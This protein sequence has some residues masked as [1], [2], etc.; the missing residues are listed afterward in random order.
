MR[1]LGQA[2][3][4]LILCEGL[5]PQ[6]SSKSHR[7]FPP[8]PGPPVDTSPLQLP[9][10]LSWFCSCILH[11]TPALPPTG[12]PT[13]K[14]HSLCKCSMHNLL[15]LLGCATGCEPWERL[16]SRVRSPASAFAFNSQ[17]ASSHADTVTVALEVNDMRPTC[18][19]T[20]QQVTVC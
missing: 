19:L 11:H 9:N 18:H 10:Y 6:G 16:C 20:D 5:L 3:D 8:K 14:T 15:R 2:N 17:D 7:T 4:V 12:L 1:D 13:V